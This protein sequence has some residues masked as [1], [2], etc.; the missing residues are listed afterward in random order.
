MEKLSCK[1]VN[2]SYRTHPK[3]FAYP[4]RECKG[5]SFQ[6]PKD[7]AGTDPVVE[8]KFGGPGRIRPAAEGPAARRAHVPATWRSYECEEKD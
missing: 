7:T 4:E 3:C 1:M 5:R 6:L 2:F 8:G